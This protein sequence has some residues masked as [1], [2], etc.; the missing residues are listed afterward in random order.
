MIMTCAGI[1]INI[2]NTLLNCVNEFI[3][4][5]VFEHE[6]IIIMII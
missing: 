3:F 6:Y 1:K 4:V 2:H 5:H